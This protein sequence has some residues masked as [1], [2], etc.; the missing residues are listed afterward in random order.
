MEE[1][2]RANEP[3]S[4]LFHSDTRTQRPWSEYYYL[5]FYRN[6]ICFWFA[7]IYKFTAYAPIFYSIIEWYMKSYIIHTTGQFRCGK[8]SSSHYLFGACFKLLIFHFCS[9]YLIFTQIIFIF[10]IMTINLIHYT[11]HNWYKFIH[12]C[13]TEQVTTT[14]TF[15]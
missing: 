13:R 2:E 6:H 4:I 15:V 14:T 12:E 10:I 3:N 9:I 11:M 5:T 7:C 8:R 1:S